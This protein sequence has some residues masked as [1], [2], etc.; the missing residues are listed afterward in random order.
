MLFP[1]TAIAKIY[2]GD[3]P[4]LLQPIQELI[5]QILLA[6]VPSRAV[7]QA[8]NITTMGC[9]TMKECRNTVLM[10]MEVMVVGNQ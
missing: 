6:M 5:D 9:T 4:T 10:G 1:L 7:L 8:S 2:I 3:L